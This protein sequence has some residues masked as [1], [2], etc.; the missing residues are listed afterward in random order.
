MGHESYLIVPAG[1]KVQVDTSFG[2]HLKA[3]K[4]VTSQSFRA[5]PV[6]WYLPQLYLWQRWGQCSMR[7]CLAVNHINVGGCSWVHIA[8]LRSDTCHWSRH[9]LW[10]QVCCLYFLTEH[11]GT[12]FVSSSFFHPHLHIPPGN[13][14]SHHDCITSHTSFL[15]AWN[16]HNSWA[17]RGCKFCKRKQ[18]NNWLWK[19]SEDPPDTSLPPLLLCYEL[20]NPRRLTLW[21][22]KD[23]LGESAV[24]PLTFKSCEVWQSGIWGARSWQTTSLALPVDNVG[25]LSTEKMQYHL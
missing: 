5:T 19:V 13:P 16:R 12:C 2:S 14:H 20:L 7:I 9:R 24:T 23:L 15:W 17:V 4:I 25:G 3:N 10:H 6:A 21:F 1:A 18:E 8:T 22:I 11:C